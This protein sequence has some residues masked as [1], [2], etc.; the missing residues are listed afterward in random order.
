MEPT[1]RIERLR[2]DAHGGKFRQTGECVECT[3]ATL[4]GLQPWQAQATRRYLK[5]PVPWAWVIAA[6]ALPGK[7]LLVGLC[8]WRL[9]GATKRETVV[10]GNADLEPLRIDRA[11][12]SRALAALE[13]AGLVRI[14][15]Q[16]GGLPAITI[17]EPYLLGRE[18]PH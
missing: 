6:S 3:P 15:R 11:A 10:L 2:W 4:G 14:K 18:P 5:G 7:A 9:R 8:I 1:T 17:Q 12:K 13:R 16:P